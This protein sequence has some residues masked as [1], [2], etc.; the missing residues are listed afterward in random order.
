M[1]VGVL[2]D[3]TC[4]VNVKLKHRLEPAVDIF[5]I[6]SIS[7]DP[8]NVKLLLLS[9]P[10]FGFVISVQLGLCKDAQACRFTLVERH[11][12]FKMSQFTSWQL[13]TITC[14]LL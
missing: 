2:I 13:K 6:R 4:S 5:E 11:I 1:P 8:H 10:Y 7:F 12:L 3:E 9:V 14:L